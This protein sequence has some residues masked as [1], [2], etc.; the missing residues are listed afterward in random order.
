MKAVYRERGSRDL[1]IP[2][3]LQRWEPGKP[4]PVEKPDPV[5]I[6]QE[7]VKIPVSLQR[8]EPGKPDPVEKPDPVDIA[9]ELVKIPVSLQRWEPGKPDPVDIAQVLVK[10]RA[11]RFIRDNVSDSTRLIMDIMSENFS[12]L[13]IIRDICERHERA[14]SSLIERLIPILVTVAKGPEEIWIRLEVPAVKKI[15]ESFMKE[16]EREMKELEREMKELEREMKE[17]E[18]EVQASPSVKQEVDSLENGEIV[19]VP[20]HHA[21]FATCLGSRES[22]FKIGPEKRRTRCL[23]IE[24]C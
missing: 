12:T 2:V 5:D 6:A 11:A 9:Q 10:E 15:Y 1:K 7:L 21:W 23:H 18:R 13:T 24:S 20:N 4:D 3:S 16:L 14:H 22:S 8:W 17:L 19:C